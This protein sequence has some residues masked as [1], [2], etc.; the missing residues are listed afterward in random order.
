MKGNRNGP[1]LVPERVFLLST[2]EW[3]HFHVSESSGWLLKC[4]N[5]LKRLRMSFWGLKLPKWEG[6]GGGAELSA[7]FSMCCDPSFR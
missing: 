7:T 1:V 6:I 5:A 4:E 2:C 3:T